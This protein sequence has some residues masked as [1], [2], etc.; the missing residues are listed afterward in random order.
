[1]HTEFYQWDTYGFYGHKKGLVYCIWDL[2]KKQLGLEHAYAFGN[3]IWGLVM[4]N[5]R[6]ALVFMVAQDK[7]F[8]Y[9]AHIW[10]S[11]WMTAWIQLL[12]GHRI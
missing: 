11:V 12:Q 10:V 4:Y 6:L 7:V 2:H 5:E 1:M 8:M 3:H 9:G